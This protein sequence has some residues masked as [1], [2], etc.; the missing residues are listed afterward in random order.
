MEEEEEAEAAGRG[1][2]AVRGARRTARSGS[3]PPRLPFVPARGDR[4]T[5]R[6]RPHRRGRRLWWLGPGPAVRRNRGPGALP[7]GTAGVTFIPGFGVFGPQTG[8][9]LE[10]GRSVGTGQGCNP[11][12]TPRFGWGVTHRRVLTLRGSRSTGF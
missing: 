11:P 4:P 6:S 3:A 10:L 12:F 1:P 7:R 8:P 5:R 9:R 2:R